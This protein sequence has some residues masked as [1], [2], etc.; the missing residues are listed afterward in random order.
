MRHSKLLLR[1]DHRHGDAA[2][3]TLLIMLAAYTY[4]TEC[5][6]VTN[7]DPAILRHEI[8]HC[9]GW[10][11]KPFAS[12]LVPPPEYD[13]PYPGK[14]TIIVSQYSMSMFTEMFVTQPADVTYDI[15]SVAEICSDLWMERGQDIGTAEQM[16]RL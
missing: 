16:G 9:N 3:I 12:V 14:L 1:C 8:A 10:K 4:P 7:G 15:R 2:M 11:H 6:V 13:H 5:I